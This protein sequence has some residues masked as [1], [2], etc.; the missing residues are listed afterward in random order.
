MADFSVDPD[1]VRIHGRTLG[2]TIAEDYAQQADEIVRDGAIDPPGFGIAL[3]WAEAL[4]LQRVEF[5]TAD[6]RGAAEVCRQIGA[7]LG[8][9]ADQYDRAED[10][11][12]SGFGG[13]PAPTGGFGDAY[14]R[15]GTAR[16]VTDPAVLATAA[17]AGASITLAEIGGVMAG[18]AACAALCPT[19]IVG[20]A[21]AA[22]FVANPVG[23]AQAGSDLIRHGDQLQK[24]L[25]ANFDK[26]CSLAT[27]TW[28]G[29]GKDSFVIMAT[30][31]KAHLDELGA[32]IRT[33]GEA[34]HSLEIALG[35]LWLGLLAMTGPFLTWLIAMR[36][37]ELVPGLALGL[38]PV[39]EA[40][41]AA[42][43]ASV[44]SMVA[45]VSTLGGLVVAL[46]NGLAKD[47]L[48]LMTLP[49]DGAA[50]TPDLTEFRVGE[51]FA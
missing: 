41:G 46:I 49:D 36:A 13:T 2:T 47:F 14:A 23:I 17:T 31:L 40:A 44:T 15:T 10:L 51:N 22:L 9:V 45:A 32:F 16:L 34:L 12:V 1:D 43:S 33:L 18:M 4:Y 27:G 37:A 28:K 21:G 19:F 5:L 50:G 39:I 48:K 38:E 25:N 42:M 11:H 35:G 20:V 6:V 7:K 26:I 29:Q 3:S 8:V 24:A 30:N